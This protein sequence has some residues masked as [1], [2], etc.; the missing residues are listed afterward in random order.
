MDRAKEIINKAFALN[1]SLLEPEAKELLSSRGI[2]IPRSGIA[3]DFDEAGVIA[4]SI[5]YPVVLKVIS[6][7]IIHKTDFGGV[8]VG[9]KNKFELKR[10]YSGLIE[11]IK[12]KVPEAE[13]IG[14]LVERMVSPSTEVIIGGLRDSQ[15][16]PAIMFGLGGVFTEILKDVSFRLA[17]ITRN[18]AFRMMEEL[19]GYPLIAGYRKSKPLDRESLSHA[20]VSISELMIEIEEIEEIDL[21]PIFLYT[22]GLT[23]VDAR[24][25]L[26]QNRN[27]KFV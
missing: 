23:A 14:I 20:I 6:P 2:P 7:Q 22:T 5:G 26:R 27:S 3:R 12:S 18:E 13:I 1:R 4:E 17:P 15:F 19:R 11:N 21:N 10:D 24:I 9:A 8:I 16:G 25:I